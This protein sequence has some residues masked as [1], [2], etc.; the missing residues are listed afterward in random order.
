MLLYSSSML[1]HAQAALEGHAVPHNSGNCSFNCDL[2]PMSCRCGLS[3]Y[4]Y[5]AAGLKE[6]DSQLVQPLHVP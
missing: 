6:K 1:A 2:L 5:R 3:F 4:L